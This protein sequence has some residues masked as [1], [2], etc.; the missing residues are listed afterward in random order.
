MYN[1]TVVA[2]PDKNLAYNNQ[3]YISADYSDLLSANSINRISIKSNSNNNGFIFNVAA[4]SNIKKNTIG[5]S[6]IQ[7]ENLKVEL[8][9]QVQVGKWKEL[10]K[11]TI[12]IKSKLDNIEQENKTISD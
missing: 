3:V 9:D 7:R 6:K 5:L 10:S 2:C 12:P 8:D 1:F 4:H 11:S